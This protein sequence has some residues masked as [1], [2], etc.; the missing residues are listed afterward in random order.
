MFLLY[1]L[2]TFQACIG[3]YSMGIE[4]YTIEFENKC[5][6]IASDVLK[7]TVHCSTSRVIWNHRAVVP[8]IRRPEDLSQCI[9]HNL[10]KYFQVD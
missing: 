5:F 9:G 2:P 1:I 6:I 4:D 7:K 3:M 10:C 8:L